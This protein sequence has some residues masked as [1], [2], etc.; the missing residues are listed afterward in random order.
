MQVKINNKLYDVVIQRKKTNRGTY[1]RVK[2][3]LK[4]Y[5]TTNYFS[6]I[7]SIQNLI[8]S[9]YD[10]IINMIDTQ[11]KRVV[12]NEGFYYLGKKYDI[13][14]VDYTNISLGENKVFIK[15]G[16]DIDKWY[17]KEAENLF[18]NKLEEHYNNFS[19][20]IPKP[21]LRIRKMTSRWGVCNI[22]THIIT[23]NLE[24]IKREEKY[25]DYV[26]VHELSHLI[27]GDHSSKFWSLVEE[28]FPKYKECRKE[29][30]DF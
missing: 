14:Y 9:N 28:N 27:Y 19:R 16:Y 24:L 18:K 1:I 4:I 6:T 29:M 12:N 10:K 3:D 17:R 7:R 2:K 30:K 25:L 21:T 15:R 8:E 11:E 23:L 26:I 5:V 13:V 20:R 22:N